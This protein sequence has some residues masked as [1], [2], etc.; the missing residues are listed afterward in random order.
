MTKFEGKQSKIKSFREE[1]ITQ[2]ENKIAWSNGP[3]DDS[4]NFNIDHLISS[5]S[6]L[7]HSF[8]LIL[9]CFD[10]GIW[11]LFHFSFFSL[12]FFLLV[13]SHWNLPLGMAWVCLSFILLHSCSVISFVGFRRQE[14][15]F[16]QNVEL[17]IFLGFVCLQHS[18]S[19]ISLSLSFSHCGI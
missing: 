15:F 5:V 16:Q 19:L 2:K 12:P 4:A 1:C 11:Q 9:L 3:N 18:S 17:V 7:L 6:S 14:L 13:S 8:S 10:E